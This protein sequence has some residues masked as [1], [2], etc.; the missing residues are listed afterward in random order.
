LTS[1]W[2]RVGAARQDPAV[3]AH[4]DPIWVTEMEL[5]APV[6]DLVAPARAE[7]RYT[8]VR[9]LVRLHR[10]PLGFLDL[11]LTDGR[12]PAGAL[13][14]TVEATLS[15]RIRAHLLQDGL[16]GTLTLAS[17]LPS[18]ADPRCQAPGPFGDAGASASVVICTRD[19]AERLRMTL[20]TV[21]ASERR[22]VEVIVVDNAPT[23]DATARVVEELADA[24]L[25]YV[26]EPRPGLARARNTGVAA[27][28]GEI[29][30]FT[31]DDVLVDRDW[32]AGL[33]RG[34]THAPDVGCVTGLIP[35][36]ELETQAQIFFEARTSWGTGLDRC[37]YDL[38][39]HRPP[40]PTFPYSA[41]AFGTGASFAI[42]RAAGDE[43]GWF[44][45][46]L[47]A[48]APPQAGEDFDMFLRVILSGRS[49]VYEPAALA[50][51]VHRRDEAALVRQMFGYGAGLTAYL[52]K[53]A[54]SRR[55]GPDIARN[56]LA[57]ARHFVGLNRTARD[58]IP[59]PAGTA[60]R[61]IQGLL[62]GP[63]LY[64]RGRRD[65]ARTITRQ[66]P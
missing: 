19:R 15:D 1:R 8:R 24:R 56:A 41:G 25:R 47:G 54:M 31:D 63:F 57:G 58:T 37:V 42:A 62:A 2:Q 5:S 40:Q 33:V 38:G 16:D 66:R 9:L 36:A 3:A 49:L 6:A 14:A 59:A 35:A 39:E 50:W 45:P 29:V 30:A 64:L 21:L 12:V 4:G 44:D 34:F 51:H 22:D 23:S 18:P 55:T 27:A 17:G 53:H 43:L 13:A 48:G 52:F 65:E 32:I 10:Q 46:A 7:A 26:L 11:D 28:R 61:E 20:D 60:R